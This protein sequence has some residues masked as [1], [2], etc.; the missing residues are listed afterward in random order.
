MCVCIDVCVYICVCVYMCV[1]ICVCIYMCIYIFVYIYMCIYICVYIYMYIP[2]DFFLWRYVKDI[3]YRTKIRDIT[4]AIVTID[5]AMLQQTWQE[6]EYRLEVLRATN[7]AH[8]E[9]Y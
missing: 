4:D 9:V 1:Y 3:V 8:V 2:L 7:G 5:E 6:I